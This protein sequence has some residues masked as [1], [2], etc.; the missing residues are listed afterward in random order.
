MCDN[1]KTGPKSTKQFINLCLA[2]L[3]A[4]AEIVSFRYD[5]LTL[6]VQPFNAWSIEID[7]TVHT[8]FCLILLG[9]YDVIY[10]V[11][12]EYICIC[13]MAPHTIP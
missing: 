1:D 2:C 7:Q 9:F 3:K 4:L 10:I 12:N 11:I 8:L 13:I 5:V 6:P